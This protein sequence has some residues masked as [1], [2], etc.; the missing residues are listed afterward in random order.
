MRCF[1]RSTLLHV[2]LDEIADVLRRTNAQRPMTRTVIPL[3]IC[4]INSSLLRAIFGI[5]RLAP[6]TTARPAPTLF[7]VHDLIIPYDIIKVNKKKP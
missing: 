1:F 7:C 6:L 2:G 3:L 4:Q 5:T